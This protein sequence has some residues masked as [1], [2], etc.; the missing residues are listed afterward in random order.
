MTTTPYRTYPLFAITV[1]G[2]QVETDYLDPELVYDLVWIQLEEGCGCRQFLVA[3]M[4]P[5]GEILHCYAGLEKLPR[6]ELEFV[7]KGRVILE[8]ETY[9]SLN[10]EYGARIK[11]MCRSECNSKRPSPAASCSPSPS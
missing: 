1:D 9:M 7:Y 2:I 11:V 6:S 5:F 3:P 8:H 4:Y 10:M